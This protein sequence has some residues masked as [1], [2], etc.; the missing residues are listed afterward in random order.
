MLT[1]ICG[2]PRAGKTTYA[3]RFNNVIHLDGLGYH[4]VKTKVSPRT[5]DITVEGVYEHPRQRARLIEAYKGKGARCI[6][7][8]TPLEVRKTRP[9]W[10]PY[11]GLE[12]IPPTLE[13]GWD[14][15]IIIRGDHEQRINRKEQT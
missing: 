3:K 6:W 13:E 7:L 14:E 5:D 11:H 9:M 8:D 10:Q 15:I 12:F 1:L 2:M 4:N